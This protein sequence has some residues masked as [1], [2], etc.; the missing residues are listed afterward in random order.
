[1]RERSDGSEETERHTERTNGTG[2]EP[3]ILPVQASFPPFVTHS[4]FQL[5]PPFVLLTFRSSPE[6]R[7]REDGGRNERVTRILKVTK[8]PGNRGRCRKLSL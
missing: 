1:M 2:N 8:N 4:P 6:R 3:R 7:S 5:P